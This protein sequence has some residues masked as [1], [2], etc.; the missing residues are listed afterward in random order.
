MSSICKIELH[1]LTA[2]EG[3]RRMPVTGG[4]RYTPTARFAGEQEQFSVVLD[5]PGSTS[6]NPASGNLRLLF[7]DLVEIAQRLRPGAALEIM[8]G[9]RVA[10]HGVVESSDVPE[11]MAAGKHS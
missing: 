5:F 9:A 6:A 3:G 8:E 11:E 4:M 1:W 2:D 7:P 10:A